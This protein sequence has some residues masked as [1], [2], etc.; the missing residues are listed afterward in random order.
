MPPV[1][2][3][4]LFATLRMPS[5]GFRALFV[6]FRITLLQNSA[7][8]THCQVVEKWVFNCVCVKYY[9]DNISL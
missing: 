9:L 1:T 5:E 7:I 8:T 6:K 4:V 3:Q 2:F